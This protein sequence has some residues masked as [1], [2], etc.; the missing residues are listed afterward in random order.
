[1]HRTTLHCTIMH[2]TTLHCTILHYTTTLLHPNTLGTLPTHDHGQEDPSESHCKGVDGTQLH[3]LDARPELAHSH[4][5]PS[6]KPSQTRF[7]KPPRRIRRH[8]HWRHRDCTRAAR[9]IGGRGGAC[10]APIS[11]R[12]CLR[13]RVLQPVKSRLQDCPETAKL[14]RSQ[15]RL[16]RNLS[17]QRTLHIQQSP[18]QPKP[19]LPCNKPQIR[20]RP[21]YLVEG[22]ERH[23]TLVH[24]GGQWRLAGQGRA[25]TYCSG[26]VYWPGPWLRG[27]SHCASA[28]GHVYSSIAQ[29]SNVL[30][31]SPPEPASSPYGHVSVAAHLCIVSVR[32]PAP[33]LIGQCVWSIEWARQASFSEAAQR[34]RQHWSSRQ[35]RRQHRQPC[36]RPQCS[37][38]RRRRASPWDG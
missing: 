27:L 19:L 9:A 33:E 2:R 15:R 23:G 4:R 25:L 14:S 29:P 18:L 24:S 5:Q 16:H 38:P 7:E 34:S 6:F 12:L 26:A 11:R 35:R 13:K 22:L 20:K 32:S 10:C 8:C 3:G 1:M 30:H 31:E 28:I 36:P 17:L 37:C 21:C